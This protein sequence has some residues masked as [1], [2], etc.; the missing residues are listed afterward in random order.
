MSV[1]YLACSFDML[2]VR[3]LEL[4]AQA[5]A[6]CTRLVAGVFSD[7]FI[8]DVYG[9]APLVP[10]RDR[11]AL[12]SHIRGV[13][14]VVVHSG[15]EPAISTDDTVLFCVSDDVVQVEGDYVITLVPNRETSS[16]LLQNALNPLPR[17]AVA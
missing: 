9:R 8:A 17:S 5:R 6:L 15:S 10:L 2:N 11:V 3:D 1:G 12:L 14:E 16:R 13:D 4:I 7:E